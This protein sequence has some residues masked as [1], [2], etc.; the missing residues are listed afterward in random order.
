MRRHLSK[1]LGFFCLMVLL[2]ACISG[3]KEP[4]KDPV[5]PSSM[6]V[7]DS[8]SFCDAATKDKFTLGYYGT[9]P[10]DTSMHFYIVC[11]KNDTIYSDQWPAKWMVEMNTTVSDSQ[12]VQNLH[13]RMRDFVAG[14]MHFE[15]DSNAVA[16]PHGQPEFNFDLAGHL[17]KRLY[18]SKE[19]NKTLEI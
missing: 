6:F 13:Q 4:E 9:Q 3:F 12:K 2:Q 17:K 11:H 7:E 8:A 16:T 1:L 10:L 5:L 19:L 14:K 15:L 18:Y